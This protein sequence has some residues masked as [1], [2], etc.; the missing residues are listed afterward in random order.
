MSRAAA[1]F[2]NDKPDPYVWSNA[3]ESAVSFISPPLRAYYDKKAD[4]LSVATREGDPKYVVVGRGTFITFADDNGIWQ[5]D[6]EAESWDSD[7]DEVLPLMK[8]EVT[9]S[10]PQW[11][12]LPRNPD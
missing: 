3:G 8:V 6:L 12:E 5:I 11:V 4:V 9:P 1:S 7:L 2:R 10:P